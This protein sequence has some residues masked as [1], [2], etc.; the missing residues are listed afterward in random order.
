MSFF[1]IPCCN[2]QT[3][4]C[5]KH[6]NFFKVKYLNDKSFRKKINVKEDI[7]RSLI[8]NNN[9]S[10]FNYERFNR[11]NFNI[12]PWSWNYR[13]CWPLILLLVPTSFESFPIQTIGHPVPYDTAL[14]TESTLLPGLVRSL[15]HTTGVK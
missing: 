6:S 13:G 15:S 8:L 5:L 10:K 4:V 9:Q 1:I 12:R 2:I 3:F 7:K 11:N 14:I